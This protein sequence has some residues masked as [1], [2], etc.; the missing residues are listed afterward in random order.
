MSF[1]QA[2]SIFPGTENWF[3]ADDRSIAFLQSGR[4]PRHARGSDVDRPFWGDG[5]AEWRDFDPAAYTFKSIPYSHRP[6]ALDPK[7]GM[8]VSWNNKEARGWRKGPAEWSN[9]PVHHAQTLE[10]RVKAEL[11]A[12]GGKIDVAG[13]TRAVNLAATTDVRGQEDYPWMRRVIGRASGEE[14]RMLKLLDAW[15]DVG[16][17]PARLQRRQP[18]RPLRRGGADGR[19]VAADGPRAVRAGARA[20]ALRV[21]RE[22]LPR[23]RWGRRLGLGD[24]RAEGP[25]LG[26]AH[27]ARP[28]AT[29]ACTAAARTSARRCRGARRSACA[30]AC[31]EVLLSSLRDAIA[32]VKKKKGGDW[33]LWVVP[34]T[35]P[36]TNP[37]GCDQIVPSTAGA[38][39]TPPFPWQNRGTFHQ[40]ADIAGH[41]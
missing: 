6:R 5:R 4:Y 38:V 17:Q 34:A 3:Y 16:L 8:I 20:E 21:R 14:E 40:V 23:R 30:R 41:R 29:H 25:A 22:K 1:Q 32:E 12:H 33:T 28:A 26:A 7:Q 18:V 19:V 2:F 35:C 36:V 9:G 27:A 11:K 10:R 24:A 39:D 13:I 31:R 15:H 37:P